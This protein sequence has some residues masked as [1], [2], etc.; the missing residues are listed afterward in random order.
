MLTHAFFK[1]LL[2][3]AAGAVIHAL[4]DRQNMKE[5]GGLRK[6]LPITATGLGALAVGMSLAHK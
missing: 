2:F 5:M 3:L 1:A 6:Y 4:A